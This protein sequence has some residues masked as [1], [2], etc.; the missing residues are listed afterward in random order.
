MKSIKYIN[1]ALSC[2][3]VLICVILAYGL[4]FTDAYKGEK[5]LNGYNRQIFGALAL[6]YAVFR[7]TTI[8]MNL[9]KI[10]REKSNKQL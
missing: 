8:Y 6:L 3:V 10:K 4:F 7:M 9:Q 5:G 2:V 1:I